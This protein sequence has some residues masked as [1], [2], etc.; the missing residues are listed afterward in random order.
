MSDGLR[1]IALLLVVGLHAHLLRPSGMFSFL[2]SGGPFE[3]GYHGV[4]IF[5]VL[6]GFLITDLL[7]RAQ[8]DIGHASLYRFCRAR[9]SGCCQR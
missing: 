2:A 3:S 1:G 7:L 9:L 4:D 5:F 6:S 8:R